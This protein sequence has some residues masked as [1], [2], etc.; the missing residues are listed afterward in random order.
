MTPLISNEILQ[1]SRKVLFI[2]HLAIGDFVYLSM[3][4]EEFAR[5][6][7]HLEIHIWVDEIRRTRCFWRWKLLRNYSLYQWLEQCWFFKKVYS[8]TYRPKMY[9]ESIAVARQENYDLVVSLATLRPDQYAVLARAIG[10]KKSFVVGIARKC[11]WYCFLKRFRFKKLSASIAAKAP[12]SIH[13][14]D[15]YAY[16]FQ[17]LFGLVLSAEQRFP[18]IQ[19]P[20]VWLLF[21]KL[22][23][24]MWQFDKKSNSFNRVF[25]I[26][27]YAKVNKRTWSLASV[28]QLITMLKKQDM[29]NDFHFI[30]NV[31]PEYY[32]KAVSYF[33]KYA[34]P[35]VIVFSA[36]ENFFQL[37]AMIKIC[38]VIISVETAVMHL[39]A[40]F[41]RP[42][43]VLMRQKNPEW[44]PLTKAPCRIVTTQKR[45]QWICDVPV[46]QVYD[47]VD[48]LLTE[49]AFKREVES[50]EPAPLGGEIIGSP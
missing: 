43:V 35:S 25:F 14:T 29:W 50:V 9:K 7:P 17:E 6:N 48:Q 8:K 2:T 32:V 39:A 47:S 44:A 41:D 15:T 49:L 24:L 46:Q 10:G 13:V 45:K 18:K 38:D 20:N 16:W 22:R 31:P 34:T 30:V 1:K 37:P 5:Q 23:L 27:A 4:F 12:G 28:A 33:K 19:I 3:F 40:A 36:K 26:N 11:S 42:M 21:A